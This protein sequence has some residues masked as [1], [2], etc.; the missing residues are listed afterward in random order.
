MGE[1]RTEGEGGPEVRSQASATGQ[2]LNLSVMLQDGGRVDRGPPVA[3][4]PKLGGEQLVR[5]G[6]V[7]SCRVSPCS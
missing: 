2:W 5:H 3:L 6:Q 1:E 4:Y 7:G